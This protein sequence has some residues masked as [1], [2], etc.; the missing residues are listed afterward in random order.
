[1]VLKLKKKVLVIVGIILVVLIAA[2]VVTGFKDNARV[3]N[4]LEPKYVIKTVSYNGEK[5]TY[6]GLGYKV[7]RY[8]SISPNEPFKNNIGLKFGS[9]LMVYKL[10]ETNE[11]NIISDRTMIAGTADTIKVEKLELQD[12]NKFNNYLERDGKTIYL[13]SNIREI[14]Y[15]EPNNKRTLKE[16]I[17]P[18]YAN[19]DDIMKG[20]T[21]YLQTHDELNDGGTQIHKSFQ[22]DI[23]IVKC[24]T[25]VG[26]HDYYIGDYNMQYD[27]E[28]MCK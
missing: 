2:G 13:A 5:V 27:N 22:Y 10:P 24:N 3:R 28:S 25:L 15:I 6:W 18:L 17:T 14:Y 11:N 4:N 20:I 21:N 16:Y 9:W 7:V 23:T 26:S 19:L 12:G 8:V 1:M